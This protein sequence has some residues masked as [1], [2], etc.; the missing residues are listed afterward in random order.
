MRQP[1]P[2]RALDERAYHCRHGRG[3]TG[4]GPR[5]DQLRRPSTSP[6]TCAA[7]SRARWACPPR[8]ST[9]PSSASRCALGGFNNCHRTCP[10]WSRRSRAASWP[11]AACR[12]PS[13]PFRSARCSSTRPSMMFRNLM[14]MDVEEMIR[15]QPMDAVVLIGGCDKTVP[16]QLM[17]AAS[18]GRARHPARHRADDDRPPSA[19]SASAPA[20][21]AAASGASYRAGTVDAAE[22]AQVEDASPSP[23]GTC[24]VMG[25]ASTMACLAEA[26]GMSLPGTAAIPAVHADRLRRRRGHRPDARC[27]LIAQPIRP[28]QIITREVGRERAA[29]AARARRLDQR[30]SSISTAIAGRLGIRCRSTGSTQLSDETPVLVDLK[31]VGDGYMEDFHAAGGVG[32][33][34]R[35][36]QPLLHLDCSTSPARPSAQR[37]DEPRRLGRPQVIRPFG[38][39][40]VEGRRPGRAVRL[41][42]ARR[43]DLQA[44]RRRRQRCSRP[45]AAPSSSPARGPRRAHRR[46]RSRRDA[47]RLPR[48]AERRTASGRHAGGRLPADPAKLARAGVKDMVRISDARMSGTAFGSVVLHVVARGG[49]R[50][51]AGRWSGTATASALSIAGKRIDLLVDAGRD[52]RGAS[53]LARPRRARRA[54][55]RRSTAS[56]VLQAAATGATSTS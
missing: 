29:R 5:P 15:A 28:S 7:R 56:T 24:A 54:A 18:A 3:D 51:P 45:R 33:V 25:T 9:G 12:W 16:A 50:R 41:A 35:E 38:R 1:P 31:P 39:S 43:R 4:L 48:A 19:A 47:R 20:P 27:A 26:L 21:T 55:T 17:G 32:A 34:L 42:R 6:A 10:S 23:P 44:R 2:C 8:C 49:R 53:R 14:A 30:R 52:W 37:L 40:A 46:S 13:R 22:I 36:L 11:P